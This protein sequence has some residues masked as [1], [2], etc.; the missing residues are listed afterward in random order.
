MERRA[1]TWS[2]RDDEAIHATGTRQCEIGEQL[3][4]ESYSGCL[5]SKDLRVL[6]ISTE[7]AEIL[8]SQV[9]DGRPMA[10]NFSTRFATS[11][12]TSSTPIDQARNKRRNRCAGRHRRDL[13]R[14]IGPAIRQCWLVGNPSMKDAQS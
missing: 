10:T 8:F 5:C 4:R 1:R 3:I 14:G 2:H 7:N 11:I 13:F 12:R 9:R 6:N